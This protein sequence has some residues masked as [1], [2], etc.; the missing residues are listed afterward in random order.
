MELRKIKEIIYRIPFFHNKKNKPNISQGQNNKFPLDFSEEEIEILRKVKDYTMTSDERLVALARAVDYIENC[1]IDGDIVECG[2][3]RGGSMMMAAFKLIAMN[4]TS[5]NLFL[6]DTFAGMPEPTDDDKLSS[7]NKA[8][9]LICAETE[10]TSNSVWCIA[11]IEEVKKALE[12]TKYPQNK[13]HLIKGKVENTLPHNGIQKISILRLDT[14]WYEST[15]HELET[16]FHKLEPGGVLLI[17]DYGH[18]TGSQKAVDEFLKNQKIK[19][20][21]NRVDY[22]GRLGIKI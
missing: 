10:R 9:K 8:A 1:E 14:D 19:M 21:L 7:N 20:F 2:V 12:L 18:W 22:T 3:W 17:D 5:R 6:F 4:K 15:K 16:L 11:T 13:I